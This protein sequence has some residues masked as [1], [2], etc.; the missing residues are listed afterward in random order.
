MFFDENEIMFYVCFL[1]WL[2]LVVLD[3]IIKNSNFKK[4][5]SFNRILWWLLFC[6]VIFIRNFV[7]WVYSVVYF[8]NNGFGSFFWGF[9]VGVGV[10][11]FFG[12]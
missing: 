4:V 10:F 1:K 6:N 5:E 3:K 12:G 11:I 9:C 8:C 7:G 2:F